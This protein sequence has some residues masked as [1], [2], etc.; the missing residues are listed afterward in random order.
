MNTFY[1]ELAFDE[2]NTAVTLSAIAAEY[3]EPVTALINGIQKTGFLTRHPAFLGLY[4][5]ISVLGWE[6]NASTNN[7]G[8]ELRFTDPASHLS[9]LVKEIKKDE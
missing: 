3:R 5:G 6:V 4:D 9:H 2:K 1:S 8:F 7:L